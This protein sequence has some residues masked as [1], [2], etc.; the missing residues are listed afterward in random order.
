MIENSYWCNEQKT[1]TE[2]QVSRL[3]TLSDD[4]FTPD[5]RQQYIYEAVYLW[6]E[7]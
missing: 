5:N 3:G 7:F 4:P 1:D 6:M 2:E